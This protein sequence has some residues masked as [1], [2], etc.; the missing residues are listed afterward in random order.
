VGVADA[1]F[2]K[3]SHTYIP[4]LF[5]SF[6]RAIS[7]AIC[8][9]K[10]GSSI[11]EIS[12]SFSKQIELLERIALKVSNFIENK[13]FKTLI[14]HPEDRVDLA[15]ERGLI[16][17]KAVA[18]AAETG[19]LGKSLLLVT[20]NFGPRV[21]LVSVFTDMP[22]VPDNPLKCQCKDCQMCITA[23]PERALKNEVC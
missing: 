5:T 7:T 4:D 20:L 10:F 11:E 14:I 21:R 13:N 12:S 8:V 9:E 3:G 18:K 2:F 1:A 16:S 19:W 17:N 6:P 23:C 15:G 22:L